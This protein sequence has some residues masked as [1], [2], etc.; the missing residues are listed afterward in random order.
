MNNK[1]YV[2]VKDGEMVHFKYIKREKVNGE[3]RYYYDKGSIGRSI[4]KAVGIDARNAYKSAQA[5]AAA[6]ENA[7]KEASSSAPSTDEVFKA[8][9]EERNS[10]QA[11]KNAY[12]EKQSAVEKAKAARAEAEAAKKE[13]PAARSVSDNELQRLQNFYVTATE[14]VVAAKKELAAAQ[15]SSNMQSTSAGSLTSKVSASQKDNGGSSAIAA[16]QKKLAKAEQLAAQARSEYNEAYKA[17]RAGAS[18]AEYEAAVNKYNALNKVAERYEQAASA[19]VKKNAEAAKKSMSS[20]QNAD[21]KIQAY[22]KELATSSAS[23]AAQKKAEEALKKYYKT[24]LGSL[25][26]LSDKGKELLYKIF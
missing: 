5:K 10:K 22:E 14:N 12:S 24:P 15:K 21:A 19:S 25:K 18:Q 11:H 6:A 2:I 13:I 16:A 9:E 8:Y 4:K 20:E 23:R 26:F 7:H 3:W 1:D 17:S